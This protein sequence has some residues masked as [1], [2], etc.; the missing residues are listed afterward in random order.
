MTLRV[1]FMGSPEFS[2]PTL[3]ALD[4][5][6]NVIGVITQPDKPR[7]RGRKTLPTPV[8]IAARDLGLPVADPDD[9]ASEKSLELL[10][11]WNPDVIVVAAYG[12]ILRESILTLPSMGCVNLHASL[13]PR[14]R[15]ASPITQAILDGD[16]VSGVTTILM[17]KGMDTG[18]ILLR[19]EIPI[20]GD[21]TG[22][23]LHDALL[24]PGAELV[25]ETL[26]KMADKSIQRRPQNHADATYTRPL[27]K[28]DGLIH[29]NR[30]AQ[31]L[32]RLVRAMNPRPGAFCYFDGEPVK[33]WNA[34]PQ[35]GRGT[36]GEIKSIGPDGI[37]VGTGEGLLLLREAQA[38]G[39]RRMPASEFAGGRR[40]K[41]GDVFRDSI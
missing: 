19:R 40:L 29:W 12:K 18:D 32:S 39:K 28:S 30:D 15:G 3:R 22:G 11:E 23:S 36:A 1:V 9:V 41:E 33:I 7:G 17:D 31:F 34:V 8:K 24:E 37:V 5:A 6:F 16:R 38:A 27:T 20:H 35:E 26:R 10:R 13:L 2:T 25:V 14:H 21:D 4:A